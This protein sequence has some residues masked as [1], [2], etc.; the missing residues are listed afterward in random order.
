MRY[1]FNSNVHGSVQKRG[2][3]KTQTE[4]P[5]RKRTLVKGM[6]FTVS[7]MSAH[8][9]ADPSIFGL[10]LGKT[11][12]QQ[13]K[14]MYDV[15][16]K[17]MNKYSSGNMYS[18]PESSIDFDGLQEV[19]TIFDRKGVLIAV[20]TNFPKSKFSYLNQA[21]GG[22]YKLIDQNIPF[23][24]NKSV[25]YRDGATEISLDAPHMSF[26]MSMNYIRDDFMRTYNEQSEAEKRQKQASESS[27][28]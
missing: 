24:G 20:L 1:K 14:A 9:F 5:K 4:Q 26:T 25:I 2:Q 28:L 19:T 11:T 8:V 23:V 21:I 7:L 22:K 15:Q 27:Q 18:V 17:G 12:E 16:P 3:A 6:A 10:E 13:L